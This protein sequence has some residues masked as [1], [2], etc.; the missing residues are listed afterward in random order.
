M[1]TTIIRIMSIHCVII[2]PTTGINAQAIS[3]G[4]EL[5]VVLPI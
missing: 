3:I 2:D 5:L 1:A 4:S